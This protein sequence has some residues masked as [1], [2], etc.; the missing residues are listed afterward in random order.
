MP[1]AKKPR[2]PTR[3]KLEADPK[4]GRAQLVDR[5][6]EIRAETIRRLERQAQSSR[7]H[8]AELYDYAP[9][10][11][12]TLDANGVIR[13]LNLTAAALLERPRAHL[14]G[15]PLVV[16][17]AP[18]DRRRFLNHLSHLRHGEPHASTELMLKPV[19]GRPVEVQMVSVLRGRAKAHG[20]EYHTALVDITERKRAEART[21]ALARLGLLLSAASDPAAAA[22]AIVEA[23]QE[24]CGWDAC[25]L[26]LHDAATDTVTH[27]VNMDTINGQRVAVPPVL[28]GSPP[29]SLTR[30]VLEEGPQFI[31]RKSP[32]EPG[33]V[34]RRFGD[35]SRPSLSLMFVPVR[36]ENRNI[37]VLS[38]QSYERNAYTP[39]G[40]GTL[41]ALA[42]HVAGALARLQAQAAL[43]RANEDLEAR[44][45]E[46]TAELRQYRDQLEDLVQQRTGELEATVEHLRKEIEN[47]QLAEVALMHTAD[48]LRRSNAELEQFA[49][50][51]SHDLQEPL[52][53]VGGYVRL[54]EHR[55]PNQVDAKVREYIEGAVEGANRMQQQITDLLAL[56][57]VGSGGLKPEWT[58]LAAPLKTALH[59]LQFAIRS[60][61]AKVTSDPLPTLPVDAGQMAQLLQNL[62]ANALKFRGDD[63]PEVHVGAREEKDDWVI[64]VQDN[65]IG[66]D[67]QYFVRI[68]QVFQRLHTRRKHPG[69]GIGLAICKKIVE[70]HGGRIWVESEPGKGATFYFSIPSKVQTTTDG[71]R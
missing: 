57:R 9:F 2:R 7:E 14:I 1:P 4:D 38:I 16:L 45:A 21:A 44:V 36:Q 55:F 49:Y 19:N 12:L 54:L 53:A 8:Y 26:L 69:T 40:L 64:W 46:R 15:R 68:F 23:A 60:T 24:L 13:T 56:S 18:S 20:Y 31:L 25:F 35:A 27:L 48:E 22:R 59:N 39:E 3:K 41:Q 33:P 65:G 42:D 34:T 50:V 43:A 11:H 70:R 10:G 58:D 28:Q 62:I 61:E 37:G 67:P 6:G 63:P 5:R 32:E 51:A 30:R 47:R 71:H 17:V 29:T 52:R 66:I